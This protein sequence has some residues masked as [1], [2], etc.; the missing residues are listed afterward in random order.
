MW[1]AADQVDRGANQ[2]EPFFWVRGRPD[3]SR[4]LTARLLELYEAQRYRGS[5]WNFMT[6]NAQ[7]HI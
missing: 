5:T 7:E 4:K 1:G 2:V 6:F 3:E